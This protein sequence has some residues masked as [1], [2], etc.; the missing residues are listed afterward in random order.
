MPSQ[1]SILTPEPSR[2][3]FKLKNQ[4]PTE[5][6][7]SM[8]QVIYTGIYKVSYQN[9]NFRDYVVLGKSKWHN[10]SPFNLLK[11]HLQDKVHLEDADIVKLALD[12]QSQKVT[13]TVPLSG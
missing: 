10:L 5:Y 6:L 11:Q 4:K 1:V 8:H 7:Y 13:V 3:T 9:D 2:D 12:N